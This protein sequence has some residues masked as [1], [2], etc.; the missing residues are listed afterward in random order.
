[1]QT[2]DIEFAWKGDQLVIHL[3]GSGRPQLNRKGGFSFWLTSDAMEEI[4]ASRPELS[5][6]SGI[7][8]SLPDMI[9]LHVSYYVVYAGGDTEFIVAGPLQ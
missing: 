1:M 7:C 8:A 3:L 4:R 6:P 5:E 9:P 2:S